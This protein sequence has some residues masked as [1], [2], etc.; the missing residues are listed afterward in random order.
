MMNSAIAAKS[1]SIEVFFGR[2]CI[3]ESLLGSS[4]AAGQAVFLFKNRM[5]LDR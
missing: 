5:L 1:G 2:G 4:F 3:G